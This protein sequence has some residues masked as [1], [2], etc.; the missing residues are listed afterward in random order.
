MSIKYNIEALPVQIY[1]KAENLGS[2]HQEAP[3]DSLDGLALDA[4][5]LDALMKDSFERDPDDL[6]QEFSLEDFARLERVEQRLFKDRTNEGQYSACSKPV[7]PSL[8][9]AYLDPS[10]PSHR[11]MEPRW[12][13]KVHASIRD[14]V[15][16]Q[17]GLE[18]WS[19]AEKH[20]EL[21]HVMVMY[22]SSSYPT[23][24]EGSEALALW[25]PTPVPDVAGCGRN[26]VRARLPTLPRGR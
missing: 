5:A 23:D 1:P 18:G 3:G 2:L 12:V 19:L 17:D 9:K 8:L 26:N 13:R 16:H 10:A 11:W 14:L 20:P 4:D 21:P 15:S 6:A 25:S 22:V 7:W 24:A